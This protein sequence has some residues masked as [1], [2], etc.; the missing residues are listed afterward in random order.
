MAFPTTILRSPA[1]GVEGMIADSSHIEVDSCV[2]KT[3]LA[4]G[5]AV[6]KAAGDA[7][8]PD[9][10]TVPTTAAMVTGDATNTPVLG[11]TLWDNQALT[12]PYV[13]YDPVGVLRQGTM[14]VISEDV[15]NP[16][17]PVYIRHTTDASG[18]VI[19]G[20]RGSAA[21]G[22]ALAARGFRWVSTTTAVNSLAKL[23][24]NLP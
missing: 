12:N 20:F 7:A 24:I 2:A 10:V 8:T 21:T 6:S 9:L 22:A 17:L 16:S 23:E 15:V 5:R 3:T 18:T 13:Q 1:I 11:V 14:W 19:G 4:P